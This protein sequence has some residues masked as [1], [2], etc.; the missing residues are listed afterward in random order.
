MI[1]V[2][3]RVPD[4]G[5]REAYADV[6]RRGVT[7]SLCAVERH[8]RRSTGAKTDGLA[9]ESRPDFAGSFL[10]SGLRLHCP[11]VAHDPP[12]PSS[13]LAFE[14]RYRARHVQQNPR[15]SSPTPPRG[16]EHHDPTAYR[17]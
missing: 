4:R 13:S 2:T 11:S 7:L 5:G 14:A 3:Y 9:A 10:A 8:C 6:A 1:G 16:K 17:R 12:V 15:A